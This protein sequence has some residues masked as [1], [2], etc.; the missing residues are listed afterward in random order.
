MTSY[1]YSDKDDRLVPEE[2]ARWIRRAQE[3]DAEAFGLL[4]E[5]Y[6]ND[7]Y[8][9]IYYRIGDSLLAEDLTETV[10][11]RVWE[12][13]SSFQIGRI[14]FRNWL[15]RVAHNLVVDEYR[16]RKET[17]HLEDHPHL[18]APGP[19]PEQAAIAKE[20]HEQLAEAMRRLR[21]EYQHVLALRFISGLR[22]S[23]VAQVLGKS[24]GTVRVLQHRALQAL[25]KILR[26]ERGVGDG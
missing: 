7:V 18:T 23:E 26:Q 1:S 13:L 3:G 21:P 2:E 8:R 25:A 14:A 19:N 20:R 22:H 17:S 9:Y 4:Y 11:L 5:R 12:K 24:E 16:A 10:F 6:L 15:L